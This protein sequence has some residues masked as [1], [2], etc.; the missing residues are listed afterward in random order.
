M[1]KPTNIKDKTALSYIQFLE[2]RLKIYTD[3]PYTPSYISIKKIVDSINF[4]IQKIDINIES[5]DA[6]KQFQQ[7]KKFASQLQDYSKQ[8]DFF[9]SRMSPE[10]IVK[11]NEEVKKGLEKEDGVEEFLNNSKTKV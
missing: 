7:I 4:Q 6:D 5:E 8:L 9:K 10:D 1:E 11:A 2:S 3:S